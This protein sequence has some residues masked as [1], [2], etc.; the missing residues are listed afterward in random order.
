MVGAAAQ[1]HRLRK[2][3]A[4]AVAQSHVQRPGGEREIRR[5]FP[6]D[7]P[8][9]EARIGAG[10]AK[11][12]ADLETIDAIFLDL[13]FA[14]RVRRSR[15]VR[16]AV[17]GVAIGGWLDRARDAAEFRHVRELLLRAFLAHT[18][19]EHKRIRGH[20]E[21]LRSHFDPPDVA[22]VGC[23]FIGVHV[24]RGIKPARDLTWQ[25]DL[26]RFRAPL[27]G[28]VSANFGSAGASSGVH[29]NEF[30]ACVEGCRGMGPAPGASNSARR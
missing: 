19:H 18:L 16:R 10:A 4:I 30:T 23:E 22:L 8:V 6:Q 7:E 2:R 25:R 3:R 27:A 21:P 11:Q 9:N 1:C 15:I 20:A 24:G 13:E 17:I 5:R 29:E 14:Q 28:S 26:L 12:I